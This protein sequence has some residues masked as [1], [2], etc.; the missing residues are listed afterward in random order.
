M[1][2]TTYEELRNVWGINIGP[3]GTPEAF[4]RNRVPE[5]PYSYAQN[6]PANMVDP[7][8]LIVYQCNEHPRCDPARDRAAIE[9]RIRQL[10]DIIRGGVPPGGGEERGAAVITEC[11]CRDG[12]VT[13]IT[14]CGFWYWRMSGCLQQCMNE[15]EQTHREQC[16]VRGPQAYNDLYRRNRWNLE[17]A[18]YQRELNCLRRLLGGGGG[19]GAD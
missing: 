4:A 9:Q 14:R 7:S 17:K 3:L 18:A 11:V 10:E 12:R 5:H 1:G 15:H 2:R 16:A 13:P 6:N 19:G 8:G